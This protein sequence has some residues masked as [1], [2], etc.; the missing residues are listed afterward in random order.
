MGVSLE[1]PHGAPWWESMAIWTVPGSD[2]VGPPG[3][4][5][6]GQPVYVWAHVLNTGTTPVQD[7]VVQFYRTPPGVGF[8]RTTATPIGSARVSLG[9]ADA[10][11]VLC[12]TA[13]VPAFTS[14]GHECLIAEAFHPSLDPLPPGNEVRA[15]TDR[16]AAQRNLSVLGTTGAAFRFPFEVDNPLRID[17]T[18]TIRVQSASAEE[19]IAMAHQL[20]VP[21]P[22]HPGTLAELAFSDQPCPQTG[23]A[24]EHHAIDIHVAGHTRVGRSLLG[25]IDGD[26]AL[27]RIEQV[28][29]GC[30]VGGLSILV[31]E[32]R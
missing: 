25:R 24:G 10:A 7:A 15:D 14:D 8:D 13:W 1:I 30:V 22:R 18:F 19:V 27:L 6:A 12:L 29:A 21:P 4:P 3:P 26:A 31:V 11:D 5:V 28:H 32:T 23:T 2:P 20:G 9:A 16:H 17:R